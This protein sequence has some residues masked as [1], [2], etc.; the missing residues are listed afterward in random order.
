MYSSVGAGQGPP[1]ERPT[2]TPSSATLIRYS[3]PAPVSPLTVATAPPTSVTVTPLLQ[4]KPWTALP[5]PTYITP[6][7]PLH[8]TK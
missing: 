5:G 2:V 8:A 3:T 7:G 1:H 6:P 4:S